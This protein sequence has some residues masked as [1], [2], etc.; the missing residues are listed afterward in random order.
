LAAF[1]VLQRVLKDVFFSFQE[2]MSGQDKFITYEKNGFSIK[3]PAGM[4]VSETQPESQSP[5]M[6]RPEVEDRPSV[7][8]AFGEMLET[9]P[10][11]SAS[12]LLV[13]LDAANIGWAYGRDNRFD[14]TGIEAA[15]RFFSTFKVT[16]TAFIPAAFVRKRPSEGSGGVN[17]KMVTDEWERLNALVQSGVLVIVPAGDDDDVYAISYARTNN[18]F[19]VSNDFYGNHIQ[20]LANMSLRS[21][22]ELWLA[23][24]R[25]SYTF[26]STGGFLLNPACTLAGLLPL[27]EN[28]AQV[29]NMPQSLL[30]SLYALDTSI[31]KLLAAQRP[32]ALKFALLARIS[33]RIELGM[34]AAAAEDARYVLH[35]DPQNEPA[36]Q[37]MRVFS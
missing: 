7:E 37:F 33:I 25:C 26:S 23:T 28:S 3:V 17:A 30:E 18:A 24:N 14:V 5:M 9:T 35:L 11:A 1:L 34:L 21:S 6:M 22:M 10:Q 20:K 8:E 19:I 13:V 36:T 2:G 12:G 32:E 27:I 29:N 31:V 4:E 16:V 15:V